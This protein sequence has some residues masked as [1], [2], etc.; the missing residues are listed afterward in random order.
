MVQSRNP[1]WEAVFTTKYS[2]SSLHHPCLLS[3]IV[4]TYPHAKRRACEIILGA[5]NYSEI[6]N[7]NY[8]GTNP[9]VG[10]KVLLHEWEGNYI[11]CTEELLFSRLK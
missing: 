11:N 2:P 8:N 9:D 10:K 5:R 7:K 1:Y 6:T 3:V 4:G